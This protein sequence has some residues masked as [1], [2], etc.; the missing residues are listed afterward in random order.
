MEAN[1]DMSKTVRRSD[2][3][4]YNS[5]RRTRPQTDCNSPEKT[6]FHLSSIIFKRCRSVTSILTTPTYKDRVRIC[7]IFTAVVMLST[8]V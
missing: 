1:T 4:R 7:V 2:R 6:R 8:A 3:E 5:V